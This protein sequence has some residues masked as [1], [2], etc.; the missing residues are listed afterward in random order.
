[1]ARSVLV[2]LGGFLLIG[3]LSLGTDV[4]VKS[5][6]PGHFDAAGGTRHVG[7]LVATLAYVFVYATFGCWLAARL[8]PSK[9]MRHAMILGLLGLAFNVAGTYAAWNTAPTWY[10]AVAL[11]LV[12][13]AA[14]LGGLLASRPRGAAL[15]PD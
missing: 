1:M 7:I 13:P 8:A 6:L 2:V 15:A 5:A 14:Y 11:L 12:L 4:L 3:V 10:H 9:P